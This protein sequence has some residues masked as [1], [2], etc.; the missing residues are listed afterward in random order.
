M[1]P[2]PEDIMHR[3]NPVVSI[4]V[5]TYNQEKYI[6]NCLQ[7]IFDQNVDFDIEVIIG[8]D[9]STD[10]TREIIFS[11]RD[12]YPEIIRLI[13]HDKNVGMVKNYLSTHEAAIGEYIC[14]LDGD[15]YFLPSKLQTQKKYLENN[16]GCSVVWSRMFILNESNGKLYDDLIDNS[17]VLDIKYSQRDVFSLGSI[18]CHSSKMYRRKAL[19][20]ICYPDGGFLDFYLNIYHLSHGY[21]KILG[22][23]LGVYRSG[24]GVLQ[25]P[26]IKKTF[27][28]NL[29]FACER[30]PENKDSAAALFLKIFLIEL[31][32]GE[33][34]YFV[35]KNF[36]KNF[37]IKT[38]LVFMKSMLLM[39]YFRSPAL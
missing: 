27:V 21:G 5:V 6:A 19:N 37:G 18:A 26:G 7:S 31:K 33:F 17:R 35:L 36:I 12:K 32:K 10:R 1:D 3:R 29:I 13:L 23:K 11:F 22:D 15:D 30:F 4:C 20:D 24:V 38:P 28:N 9:A 16:A 34:N 8:E 14:H 25:G 2:T 39:K